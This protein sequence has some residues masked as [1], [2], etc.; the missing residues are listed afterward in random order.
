MVQIRKGIDGIRIASGITNTSAVA[1]DFYGELTIPGIIL[2]AKGIWRINS[3]ETIEAGSEAS[4]AIVR[5]AIPAGTY[6]ATFVV[7]DKE[8]G[9]EL[10]RASNTFTV[11]EAAPVVF[12]ITYDEIVSLW[13]SGI[14]TDSQMLNMFDGATVTGTDGKQYKM[15]PGSQPSL[16]ATVG[17]PTITPI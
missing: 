15:I 13:V 2:G 17:I 10:G 8:G 6:T 12:D 16:S 9:I 11:V 4:M 5:D 1:W 14:I 3:N 7:Y